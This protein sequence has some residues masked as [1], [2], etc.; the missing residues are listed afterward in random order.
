VDKRK[1]WE[2]GGSAWPAFFCVATLLL[3]HAVPCSA[4]QARLSPIAFDT[5]AAVD[6]AVDENGNFATGVI[7]DAV[8]SVELGRGFEAFA[9]PFIQRLNS[10]EWNRQVW[11]AALRYERTGPIALRVDAGLIPSPVGLAN[12]MLRPQQNPTI[13]LPSS[14]FTPLPPMELRGPR[15]NLLGV[16]YPYGANVTISAS[17]WDLRGAVIDTSPLRVRR[18]FARANPPQFLNV[19][20][21]G[22]VTPVVGLRIGASLTH[23]GWQKAGESPTV[24]EDRNATVITIES[25]YS[26][27]YTKVSGEWVRDRLET[28]T[29]DETASGWFVQGQQTLTARWFAAARAE[30]MT[31]PAFALLEPLQDQHFT[32][33]EETVGYRVTPE[34]TLRAGHRGRRGFGRTGFDN[35]ATVSIVWWQRWM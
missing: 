15:T 27:R 32:G 2:S 6:E 16:L 19:V 22:G 34:I 7:L 23:G 17:R 25:E 11:I 9:R 30:R 5:V 18:I 26:V 29:G 12:M 20:V 1:T 24:T 33:V 4:Q 8:V 28:A 31:A 14:L 3:V 13:A 10:G 21:G 35:Q